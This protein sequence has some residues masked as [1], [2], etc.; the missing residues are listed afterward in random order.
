MSREIIK[1]W[2]VPAG[3][4]VAILVILFAWSTTQFGSPMLA[5]AYA[6]GRRIVPDEA[7][8]SCGSMV[9]GQERQVVFRISNLSATPVIL[10]GARSSCTCTV[11]KELPMTL[12]PSEARDL[13]VFVRGIKAGVFS[14]S[15]TI[16]S[17]SPEDRALALEIIGHVEPDRRSS[18]SDSPGG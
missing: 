3:T 2:A 11:A 6:S 16:L 13:H 5:L 18:R 10:L 9:L 14:E 8:K 4:I 12:K 15:I 7:R 1:A 17:N